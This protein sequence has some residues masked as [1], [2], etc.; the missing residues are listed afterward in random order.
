MNL[1]HKNGTVTVINKNTAFRMHNFHL[2]L[3]KLCLFV[4]LQWVCFLLTNSEMRAR[5]SLFVD[6]VL[7]EFKKF[8]SLTLADEMH[9]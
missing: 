5:L 9:T 2:I 8:V 3:I 4:L 1:E 6:E 7:T